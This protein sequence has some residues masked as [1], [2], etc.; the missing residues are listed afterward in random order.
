MRS[1]IL[2]LLQANFPSL[3][4]RIQHYIGKM[5][6]FLVEYLFN[7]LFTSLVLSGMGWGWQR[8]DEGG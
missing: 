2:N 1:V 7:A 3:W 6:Q 8:L 5:S 4:Q